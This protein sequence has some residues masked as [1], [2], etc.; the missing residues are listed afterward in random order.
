MKLTIENAGFSHKK[1]V[2]IIQNLNFSAESGE[3]VA[4]LG[5]N[6]A[7]KTTLL[8]CMMGFL[9]WDT[10]KSMLDGENIR[11]IPAKRLWR[12]VSYV[13]QAKGVSSALTGREMILL[14]CTNRIGLFSAPGKK[15]LQQVEELAQKL[16]ITALLD[17]KCSQISG[18]ELQ[19]ILIAR[20]LAARPELLILDEPESNLDFKNQL[21]VLETISGL[22]SEGICCI[23]NTHYPTHALLHATKSLILH[24][25]GETIFG[26]TATVLTEEN[27]QRAFG[28]EAVIG[29]IETPGN[30]YRSVLPLK[31]AGEGENEKLGDEKNDPRMIA[32]LSIIFQ[33]FELGEKINELLHTY[34]RYIVGRMGMPYAEAGVYIINVTVDAPQSEVQVL[35]HKLGILP[36]VHAKATCVDVE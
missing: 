18:G 22:A 10:G 16:G 30:V 1:G 7:G 13:P 14:G 35:L 29:E 31:I 11:E 4:I 8:R 6:G 23:F 12:R 28:V 15:E 26:D 33:H 19:M 34:S 20:A 21:I 3:V 9:R 2:P 24:K 17:K 25:G 36:G 32:V 5:P 27:I